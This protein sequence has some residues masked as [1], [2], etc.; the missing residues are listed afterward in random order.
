MKKQI[1][2]LCSVI[3]IVSCN[4][5]SNTGKEDSLGC[6]FEANVNGNVK[7]VFCKIPAADNV[8][9]GSNYG[10]NSEKPVI[11]RNFKDFQ[12]G[13]YEV[14]QLQ[15]KALKNETW[16][17]KLQDLSDNEPAI[18]VSIHDARD[19]ARIMTKSD[20]HWKYRLPTEAEWEYAARADTK[21]N[22]YWGKDFNAEYAYM[23]GSAKLSSVTSCPNKERQLQD[24]EYCSNKFGLMHMLGNVSEFVDDPYHSYEYAPKDG[25]TPFVYSKSTPAYGSDLRKGVCRYLEGICSVVR[26]GN[27]EVAGCCNSNANSGSVATVSSRFASWRWGGWGGRSGG[28]KWLG[29]RL[30]RIPKRENE[31]Q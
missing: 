31:K 8:L 5:N 6:S 11:G 26:G 22:Y 10:D 20:P 15:Y 13:K 21:T 29:F 4:N 9:I 17:G 23:G 28:T 19:Y 12:I 2:I 25:N 18:F 30:V 16:I 14:T 7:M 27:W 3:L 24:S 1:S